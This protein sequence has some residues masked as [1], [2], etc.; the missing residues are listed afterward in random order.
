MSH[1]LQALE[2]CRQ[3]AACTET[4]GQITRTFL[5]PPMRQCH[6]LLS[7]RMQSLGMRVSVDAIG[8]LRG[9]YGAGSRPLLLIGSHL[10]TVPNAGA[11]DGI[12]GVTIALSVI[13]ALGSSTLPFDI[14]VLAFS[15]EEGVRFRTPFLGSLAAIGRFDPQL[16]HLRDAAGCT[17]RDAILEYGLDPEK[18]PDAAV[19]PR[20]FAF[21]EFHIEQGPVLDSAHESLAA[22]SAIA[23]QSRLQIVFRGRANHAGTTPMNLRQDALAAAAA[24]ITAVERQA[25]SIDGLVA[26]VGALQVSPNAGNVIPSEARASL[27]VRHSYDASRIEAVR[28]ICAEASLIA[29]RRGLSVA[30]EEQLNQ[31]AVTM[32][33]HLT[34]IVERAIQHVAE[35]AGAP[36]RRMPSGA[37]HDAMIMASKL[38]SAMLFIRSI[39]GVSHHPSEAV[40]AEDVEK[41]IAA[42]VA[43]LADLAREFKRP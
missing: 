38:S 28:S 35:S 37:G 14:E 7:A 10:D 5:S 3:I 16:L 11:Y 31:N 41:A 25:R 8:N 21:L 30:F 33:E 24:W 23:G 15:E 18:I 34:A 42:G 19:D 17:L 20:T 40:Y 39:D 1:S 12:L 27:D 43:I 32:D 26:T 2:L 9:F 6:R 22:V 13:E 4:A 36:P 29:E